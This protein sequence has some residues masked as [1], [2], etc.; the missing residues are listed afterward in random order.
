[1]QNIPVIRGFIHLIDSMK[2]GYK[3]LDWSAEIS[4]ESTEKSNIVVEKILSFI[5]VIFVIT[6]FMGIPYYL[7][8]LGL[9]NISNNNIIFNLV[10]GIF[11]LIIFI[12]YL[13]L[14]SQLKEIKKLF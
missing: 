10:A 9:T 14:L 5:S 13:V 1:M 3:T 2:I 4:E 7:T 8:E 6:L 11:R 12:I